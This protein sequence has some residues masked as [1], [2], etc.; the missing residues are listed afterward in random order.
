MGLLAEAARSRHHIADCGGMVAHQILRTL[1]RGSRCVLDRRS[2]FLFKDIS[3]AL[4]GGVK[5]C[6]LVNEVLVPL[7]MEFAL[8]IWA[9][10]ARH[11]FSAASTPAFST[12]SRL[13]N[14]SDILLSD[15]FR[16]PHC[17]GSP[18]ARIRFKGG[19]VCWALAS[20]SKSLA[21]INKSGD[22]V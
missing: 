10:R 13:S 20:M 8:T 11:L 9:A 3:S 16:A 15:I 18:V 1:H 7:V 12:A 22:R 4:K 6:Q 19:G 2:A 17:R 5:V 21:Q 14:S